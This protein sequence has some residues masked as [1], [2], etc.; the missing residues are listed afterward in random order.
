M[1]TP[2]SRPP[3]PLPTPTP[4]PTPPTPT[5]TPPTPTPTPPPLPSKQSTDDDLLKTSDF[6]GFTIEFEGDSD[7]VS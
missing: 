2:C 1:G 4:T 5:P 7:E 6:E 3:T